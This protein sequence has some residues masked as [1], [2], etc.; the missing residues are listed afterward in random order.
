[1]VI[2]HYTNNLFFKYIDFDIIGLVLHQENREELGYIYGLSFNN[3]A[4]C[5]F[6]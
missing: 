4:N 2:H 3:P 6:K 1:M 5:F